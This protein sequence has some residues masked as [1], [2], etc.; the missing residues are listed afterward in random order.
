MTLF[1]YFL[2]D[3][4]VIFFTSLWSSAMEAMSDSGIPQRPK[5][6]TQKVR[7]SLDATV[8]KASARA[9]VGE[10]RT[11]DIEVDK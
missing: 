10:E 8:S 3:T 5:P 11:L 7:F 2:T 6:P 9:T 4:A 1:S